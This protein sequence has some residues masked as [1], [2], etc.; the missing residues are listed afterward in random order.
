MLMLKMYSKGCYLQPQGAAAAGFARWPLSH[1]AEA[2]VLQ[3]LFSVTLG[4][5][6]E[7]HAGLV[8]C[9]TSLTTAAAK[10]RD[11]GASPEECLSLAQ[12][13]GKAIGILK[14]AVMSLLQHIM[15]TKEGECLLNGCREDFEQGTQRSMRRT[16][17]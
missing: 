8:E 5:S 6:K 9:I 4:G 16:T 2:A 1:P 13:I 17:M 7:L 3:E 10:W 14:Q 15:V 12:P 11:A